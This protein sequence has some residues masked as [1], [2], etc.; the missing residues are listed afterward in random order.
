MVS[1]T[2]S[3]NV[4]AS[5]VKGIYAMLWQWSVLGFPE[6]LAYVPVYVCVTSG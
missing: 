2:E 3:C 5:G 1:I 4:C 6:R